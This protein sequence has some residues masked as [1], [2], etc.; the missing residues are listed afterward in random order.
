[1]REQNNLIMAMLFDTGIHNLI[2]TDFRDTY[3]HIFGKGKKVRHVPITQI[4]NKYL[5]RYNRARTNYVK[6]KVYYHTEY[7]LLSQ[8]GK[9]NC[10]IVGKNCSRLWT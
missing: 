10:R 4:P 8:K 2:M 7:L 9:N 3:I 6:D 5:I 1:M